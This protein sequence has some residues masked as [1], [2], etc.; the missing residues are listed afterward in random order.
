MKCS[1][2]KSLFIELINDWNKINL[3]AKALLYI[4]FLLLISCLYVIFTASIVNEYTKSIEVTLRAG[5]SSIFGFILSSNLKCEK[6]NSLSNNIDS[7]SVVT[8]ENTDKT[9]NTKLNI[10]SYDTKCES[11]INNYNY[12]EGN[13]AQIL[14]ALAISIISLLALIYLYMIHMNDAVVPLD[15]INGV[16]QLRDLLCSSIGFLLGEASIKK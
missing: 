10:N 16:G 3:S 6:S 12:R 2:I 8:I 14:I 13:V 7:S 11:E 15:K 5:L 4:G 9:H 1:R